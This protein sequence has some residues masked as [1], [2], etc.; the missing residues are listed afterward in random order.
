MLQTNLSNQGFFT[1]SK[2]R[3]FVD[4]GSTVML[5]PGNVVW[6]TCVVCSAK[7]TNIGSGTKAGSDFVYLSACD[8]DS[9]DNKRF[10]VIAHFC[11]VS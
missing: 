2:V 11:A 4:W 1:Q 8:C 10:K 6:L 9:C 7:N 3:G 5:L